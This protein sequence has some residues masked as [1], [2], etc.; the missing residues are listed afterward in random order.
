MLGSEVH[1]LIMQTVY[2]PSTSTF[3]SSTLH[4][5]LTNSCTVK[6]YKWESQLSFIIPFYVLLSVL[7]L[8]FSRITHIKMYVNGSTTSVIKA[9][10]I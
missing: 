6:K 1:G 5:L 9:Q 2:F 7:H 8:G 3:A 4:S 10:N